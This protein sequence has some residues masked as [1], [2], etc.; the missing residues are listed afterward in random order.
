MNIFLKISLLLLMA[1]L[2]RTLWAYEPSYYCADSRLSAGRWVKVAV[3]TTGIHQLSYQTLR[4]LGF[5]DPAK[6]TVHG[7]GAVQGADNTF[8][9]HP[10]DLP[11][12]H[13]LHT[14]DGR[15]LFYAEGPVAATLKL[16]AGADVTRNA[17]S[18]QSFY[19]LTD[20]YTA[21]P[22]QPIE[23][24]AN[25]AYMVDKATFVD[26][27]EKETCNYGQGGALYHGPNITAA[28]P[29][30]YRFRIRNLYRDADVSVRLSG[31]IRTLTNV[32]I[33]PQFEGE[34]GVA[35]MK[36][37]DCAPIISSTKIWLPFSG[38]GTISASAEHPMQ[39]APL[40][41]SIP[42]PSNFRGPILAADF[43][44]L[45][46]ERSLRLEPDESHLHIQLRSQS[47]RNRNML[48]SD[49]PE[50]FEVWDVSDHWDVHPFE[51]NRRTNQAL[52]TLPMRPNSPTR[53][54]AFDPD[55]S[56]AEPRIVGDVPNQNIHALPVPHMVIITTPLFRDAA[57]DLAH[58][59]RRRGLD[60]HVVMQGDIFNEF[61]SGAPS[62]AAIRR[63]NKMFFD[64]D[65][66]KFRFVTLYGATTWDP[67]QL[68]GPQPD[69]PLAYLAEDPFHAQESASNFANDA[70][71][72]ILSDGSTTAGI[73]ALNMSVAVGRISARNQAEA[74]DYNNKVRAHLAM[75]ADPA[76]FLRAV[77]SSC[78]GDGYAH[79]DHNTVLSDTL[80][81]VNPN[82]MV[83]RADELLFPAPVGTQWDAPRAIADAL[84]QGVGLFA[85]CG[86]GNP[87]ALGNNLWNLRH[88]KSTT[89]S[90]FPLALLATCYIAPID[91]LSGIADRMVLRPDGG[92]IAAIG[93]C[94]SVYLE[95]NK[96]L[97]YAVAQAYASATPGTTM[98]EVF[99]NARR[100]LID[101]G[102]MSAA[103]GANTLCYNF[104]GDPSIPMAIPEAKIVVETIFG[105]PYTGQEMIAPGLT[106]QITG[107]VVDAE[108]NLMADFNGPVTI[109]LYR[110]PLVT[111]TRWQD[112]TARYPA[113]E[114][115][116]L[117][118]C[119]GT[120][121]GGRLSAL[122]TIPLSDA[123]WSPGR[124]ILSA[125]DS[126]TDR[127]AAGIMR[128][129]GI[130]S[131]FIDDPAAPAAPAITDFEIDA[132]DRAADGTVA[133]AFNI[134]LAVHAPAGLAEGH[135]NFMRRTA[136]RLDG[137]RLDS[138]P[139]DGLLPDAQGNI[140]LS[141]PMEVTAPGNHT[142]TVS[143]TDRLGRNASAHLDFTVA[144]RNY[145]ATL[146]LDAPEGYVRKEAIFDATTDDGDTTPTGRLIIT[147]S[148]GRTVLSRP[149]VAFPFRWDLRDS[150]GNPVPNGHYRA[151]LH[152]P[153]HAA[154]RL[155]F[156]IIK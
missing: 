83:R 60:V 121:T 51:L 6:V 63:M 5:D 120:I 21:A 85:Y 32:N 90:R 65:P 35:E 47:V 110:A 43:I 99:V 143:V 81:C 16:S 96:I 102:L 71:F 1:V 108:G 41:I 53:L 17:Y 15:I 89:Y 114:D 82:M 112:N 68:S 13:T 9:S 142:L 34:I 57:N 48:F 20:T 12:Q 55:A 49:V 37:I 56:F 24:V 149:D 45:T 94:R 118:T 153:L 40:T 67:R 87:E 54:V 144:P 130:G 134:N 31:V 104:I 92:A 116:L 136:L 50:H 10:D 3:D 126:R 138:D 74:I 78:D 42:M 113:I 152:T 117:T 98:G 23:Y 86:H 64:R 75:P 25:T 154:P 93:A 123:V 132:A 73:Y 135:A 14:P 115:A 19:F 147:D 122:V 146:S 79:F 28:N 137:K 29:D 109:D 131:Q 62:P 156:T 140:A 107:K 7:Y 125:V 39:D 76:V 127:C 124:T 141:V 59:H 101:R 30:T 72:G 77:T 145:A 103:V 22:S 52:I 150:D 58:I 139:T 151:A 119:H 106:P 129:P 148:H 66:Q 128:G 100:M 70:Y 95:R 84:T 91:R 44:Y 4:S 111:A 133:P 18:S 105:Q 80:T 155:P 33:V 26:Y 11:L 46:Y 8:G 61:G 2:P 36:T 97:S 27:R 69:L 38:L 88:N